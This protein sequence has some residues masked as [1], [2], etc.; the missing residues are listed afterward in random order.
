MKRAF[1][2][3]KPHSV[4]AN[5]IFGRHGTRHGAPCYDPLIHIL[6]SV[7]H[8]FVLFQFRYQKIHRFYHISDKLNDHDACRL[9]IHKQK[10]FRQIDAYEP[11]ALHE[12][13]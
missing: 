12:T 8:E 7:Q 11:A 2:L 10:P 5:L 4:L 13:V 9:H 3:A 6:Y 1:H